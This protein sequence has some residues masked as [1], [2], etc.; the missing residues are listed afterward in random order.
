MPIR[1]FASRMADL[2]RAQRAHMTP[3]ERAYDLLAR[4]VPPELWPDAELNAFCDER[5]A[6]NLLTNAELDML[7]ASPEGQLESLFAQLLLDNHNYVEGGPP[8][9]ITRA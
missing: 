3:L 8:N 6:M 4:H 2:E 5:P 9:G 7:I 1:S